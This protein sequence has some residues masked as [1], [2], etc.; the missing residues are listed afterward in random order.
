IAIDDEGAV[1]SDSVTVTVG[2]IYR[3]P[4]QIED[5]WETAS[6]ESVNIDGQN[7]NELI[8]GIGNEPIGEVHSILIIKDGKLVFEE[9]FPGYDFSYSNVN[10]HGAYINFDRDTPH[11]THSATKSIVSTLIGVAIENG[12]INSVDD[13]LFSYF[14]SYR[15]LMNEENSQITIE[16]LLTMTS[17]FEWNEWDVPPGDPNYDT[18]LFNISSDPISY[19]LSKPIVTEPGSS[20]YYNGAGVDLLG[21]LITNASGI[22]L[23]N[24]AGQYLFEPLGVP[25]YEFQIHPSGMVYA[26]GDIY[27]TPRS[28]AKYGFL[29]LNGGEWNGSQIVSEVWINRSISYHTQLPP[30]GWADGYG[31]LI[32]LQTFQNGSNNINSISA[33]GWGGQEIYVFPSL[34]MVVVFTGANYLNNPPCEYILREFIFP[35]VLE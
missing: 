27:L 23:D 13:S 8:H 14:D 18:H 29:L 2:W 9:Y 28:M 10:F 3:Q 26:H 6:L 31:Y 4:E 7:F 34:D 19:V 33:R 35:A 5:G 30:I 17:G 20:F 21:Q 12:F 1:A 15:N 25:S 16:H 32:W 24:F 22:R 11:N